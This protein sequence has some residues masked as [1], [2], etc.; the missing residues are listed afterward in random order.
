MAPGNTSSCQCT[1]HSLLTEHLNR[2]YN[3][4]K[5]SNKNSG[6]KVRMFLASVNRMPCNELDAQPAYIPPGAI[7]RHLIFTRASS[8][9]GLYS[10]TAA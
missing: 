3:M 4:E 5:R 9:Y 8:V 7:N 10:Q 1:E 6:R 2:M